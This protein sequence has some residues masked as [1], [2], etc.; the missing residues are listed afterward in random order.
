M[1][2]LFVEEK[3]RRKIAG[4]KYMVI[5]TY[6]SGGRTRPAQVFYVPD[7]DP[8]LC[9]ISANGSRCVQDIVE[10]HNIAV[11]IFDSTAPVGNYDGVQLEGKAPIVKGVQL[12]GIA[13]RLGR[14]DGHTWQL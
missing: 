1:P 11:S 14:G 2:E 13:T 5:A 7:S 8:N 10:N 12:S 9:F 3:A 6:A 4:N